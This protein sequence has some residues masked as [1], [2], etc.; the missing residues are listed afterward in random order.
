MAYQPRLSTRALS[1]PSTSSF[2]PSL[3]PSPS[4]RSRRSST[5]S[6]SSSSFTGTRRDD[7]ELSDGDAT[8]YGFDPSSVQIGKCEWGNH[9]GVE[10]WELE[11]LAE[12]I[13]QVHAF[14]EE[15]PLQNNVSQKRAAAS[16]I[17]DWQ[18]C[19][20]RGKSQGSKFALVAHL[21]S[22]TGEKPFTC[23]RAECDKS[24]TRTDALQ[25]HM[26]IQHQDKIITG[27]RPP[28]KKS[29]GGKRG[30]RLN[31][32]D[33]QFD[34]DAPPGGDD[35]SST[36]PGEDDPNHPSNVTSREESLAFHR[37]PELSQEFVSYVVS[38][39]KYAH[40]IKEHEELG[41]E[42]EAVQ[43]REDELRMECEE[44]LKGI[45]RK[46]VGEGE[47]QGGKVLLDKFLEEYQHEPLVLPNDYQSK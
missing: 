47:D 18:G 41:H 21:R 15:N 5:A 29:K 35:P 16:Y 42:L 9:C 23:P 40:L 2:S 10:F 22:H 14:P 46:E 12:H 6:S 28:S 33:S 39:A 27:R 20:R 24:F 34:D 25:K 13:H 3:S 19:P 44:L 43:T 26:R 7:D 37:H 17:C 1:Q 4:K 11:P 32:E 38:K 30:E 31:S 8:S 45:L 36:L